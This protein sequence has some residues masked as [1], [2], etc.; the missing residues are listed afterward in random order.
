TEHWKDRSSMQSTDSPRDSKTG[1]TQQGA[2][3]SVTAPSGTSGDAGIAQAPYKKS[4]VSDN[5]P[6]ASEPP[7]SPGGTHEKAA[8]ETGT[9]KTMSADHQT[10]DDHVP[11]TKDT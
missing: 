8:T 6:P 1:V 10:S 11:E 9:K 5:V 4:L 2:A 3:P 7:S